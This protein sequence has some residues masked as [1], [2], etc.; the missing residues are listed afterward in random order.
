MQDLQDGDHLDD[1]GQV[2][3]PAQPDDVDRDAALGQTTDEVGE[4][5]GLAAQDGD[6]RRWP[7]LGHLGRHGVADDGDLVGGGQVEPDGELAAT[8]TTLLRAEL[9]DLGERLAQGSATTLAAERMTPPER[10]F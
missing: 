2:E 6:L 3:Q 10:L 8:P 5:L 9:G 7:A 4:D 1:L